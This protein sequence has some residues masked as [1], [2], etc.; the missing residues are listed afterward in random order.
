VRCAARK[1]CHYVA[2][3]R[4]LGEVTMPIR[5]GKTGRRRLAAASKRPSRF[6]LFLEAQELFVE[7]ADACLARRF[8]VQLKV[9]A[10]FVERDEDAGL[11]VLAVLQSPAEQ[12]RAIAEH[13]ATHLRG[14]VL[15][16]EIRR[17]PRRRRSGWRLRRRPS[18]GGTQ[19]PVFH[20]RDG[21]FS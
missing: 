12:L 9:A 18:T 8:D 2:Q 11:D 13:D 10:C 4:R 15:E 5:R 1:R 7:I 14:G 20:E 16:R 19:S 6:E 21:S 17:D 3:C